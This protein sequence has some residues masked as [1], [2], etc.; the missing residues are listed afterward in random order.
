MSQ[1]P[2]ASL[3]WGCLVHLGDNEEHLGQQEEWEAKTG[4]EW[5]VAENF[6]QA[7]GVLGVE[8]VATTDSVEEVGIN[9]VDKASKAFDQKIHGHEGW[10]YGKPRL[11]LMAGW[12]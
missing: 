9:D 10:P 8:V 1:E 3:V 6:V 11:W 12:T 5:F 2:T 7:D 4:L